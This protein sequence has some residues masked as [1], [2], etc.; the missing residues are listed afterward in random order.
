MVA[1]MSAASVYVPPKRDPP[2]DD[3]LLAGARNAP[4]LLRF[5]PLEGRIMQSLW[6]F[7]EVTLADLHHLLSEPTVSQSALRST[8]EKLHLK[9]LVRMRKVHRTCF[10]RPSIDQAIFIRILRAQLSGFLGGG[11]MALLLRA[12]D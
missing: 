12:E 10:Y 8:L 7:D 9:R 4:D 2:S 11:G 6:A 5:G 1:P 3:F